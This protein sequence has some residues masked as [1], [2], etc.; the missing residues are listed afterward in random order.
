VQR[1]GSRLAWHG[2]REGLG[3]AAPA[4]STPDRLVAESNPPRK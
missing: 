3:R 1:A 2:D 4:L